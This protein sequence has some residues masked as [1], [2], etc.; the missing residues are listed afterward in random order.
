MAL[1]GGVDPHALSSTIR[2]QVGSV[3]RYGSLSTKP[4]D[5]WRPFTWHA[6]DNYL[7]FK[8]ATINIFH[9]YRI[10]SNHLKNMPPNLNSARGIESF[11]QEGGD[12][13]I[14]FDVIVD[15]CSFLSSLITISSA[16]IAAM[17]WLMKHKSV[18]RRDLWPPEVFFYCQN[19][20]S[21][22]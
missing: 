5:F 18:W 15:I 4:S 16:V 12:F 10:V 20:S 6:F 14:L 3:G 2:F 8:Q 13:I 7:L 11:L 22:K 17:H 19:I 9:C 21:I 1:S